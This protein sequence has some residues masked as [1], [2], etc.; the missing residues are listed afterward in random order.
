MFGVLVPVSRRTGGRDRARF[1][2]RP[3]S[4]R[5]TQKPRTLSGMSALQIPVSRGVH[6][7]HRRGSSA[8]NNQ[9]AADI[10]KHDRATDSRCERVAA[11]SG[12]LTVCPSVDANPRLEPR[13]EFAKRR[14]ECPTWENSAVE[15]P[16][17]VA[18]TC[19]FAA[20][21]ATRGCA[22]RSCS[23]RLCFGDG[24][25][26]LGTRED[27]RNRFARPSVSGQAGYYVPSGLRRGKECS[28]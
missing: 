28:L 14:W 17:T 10:A 2:A 19:H 20:K 9:N 8:G 3:A 21:S 22:F 11:V 26:G 5:P 6:M 27:A 18:T 13:C 23:A 24:D 12:L 4:R 25:L 7:T 1:D 16:P 15:K